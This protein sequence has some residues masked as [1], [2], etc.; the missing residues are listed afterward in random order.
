MS[1]WEWK[2]LSYYSSRHHYR[3]RALTQTLTRTHLQPPT[4]SSSQLQQLPIE[5]N[6]LEVVGYSLIIH[7]VQPSCS[8]ALVTLSITLS[9]LLSIFQTRAHALSFFPLKLL[10]P[11]RVSSLFHQEIFAMTAATVVAARTEA[12]AAA[13]EAAPPLEL[14]RASAS[15]LLLASLLRLSS[16][17][18]RS[19]SLYCCRHLFRGRCRI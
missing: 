10:H 3:Q 5:I 11:H 9:Q 2:W 1:E 6:Q 16:A 13:A 8:N 17:F 15:F 14:W 12:V 18:R 4:Q 7:S 19:S